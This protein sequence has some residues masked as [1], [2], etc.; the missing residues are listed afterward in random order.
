[1]KERYYFDG[2]DVDGDDEENDEVEAA[3][4]EQ[5]AEPVALTELRHKRDKRRDATLLV[6]QK[7]LRLGGAQ[8]VGE[9]VMA[10]INIGA[11]GGHTSDWPLAKG[12][13]SRLDVSRG[14]K[15]SPTLRRVEGADCSHGSGNRCVA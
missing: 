7:L 14:Q 12:N 2:D 6:D 1:M 3:M 5:E 11:S 4:Y 10:L 13:L 15:A 8:D 9:H